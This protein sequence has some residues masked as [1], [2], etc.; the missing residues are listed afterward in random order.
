[1]KPTPPTKT[2]RVP[3]QWA[4]D[5][6]VIAASGPS[7][8]SAQLAEVQSARRAGACKLMVI[9]NTWQLAPWADALYACDREWWRHYQPSF[10]GQKWTQAEEAAEFGAQYVSGRKGSELSLDPSFIYWGHDSG[11]QAINL[12]VHFG[13]ARIILIGFDMQAT[14]Y[15]LHWHDDHVGSPD[16][17]LCNPNPAMFGRWMAA[18]H[19]AA[20]QLQDLGIT[21]INAT[22]DTALTCFDRMSVEEAL[23]VRHPS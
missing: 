23:Y 13:V 7:L 3:R 12:S 14:G 9:N 6:V 11:F 15:Q 22:L 4:N 17:P 8:S 19:N 10:A 21:C 18:Y 16:N 2:D 1:M 5:T 20:P